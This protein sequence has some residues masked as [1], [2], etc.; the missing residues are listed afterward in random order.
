MP[1]AFSNSIQFQKGLKRIY[2]TIRV[3]YKLV[4]A[5]SEKK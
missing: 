3:G 1:A 4:F 5:N 2:S